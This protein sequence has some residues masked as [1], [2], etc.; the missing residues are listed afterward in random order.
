MH[1]TFEIRRSSW[2]INV[3]QNVCIKGD[4][5]YEPAMNQNPILTIETIITNFIMFV[6]RLYSTIYLASEVL[7]VTIFV[8]L[9]PKGPHGSAG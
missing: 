2:I 5:F 9:L 4:F 8:V 1:P 6:F 7:F 3:L